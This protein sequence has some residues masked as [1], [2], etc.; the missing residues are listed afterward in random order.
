MEKAATQAAG[1]NVKAETC[2]VGSFNLF[3][4][5]NRHVRAPA[6]SKSHS[7]R[8]QVH[9]ASASGQSVTAMQA[10]VTINKP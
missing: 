4:L 7:Q 5:D 1:Y 10:S 8:Y 9:N 2:I 6:G 3:A